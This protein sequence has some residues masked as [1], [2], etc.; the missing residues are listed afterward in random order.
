MTENWTASYICPRTFA[1]AVQ[2]PQPLALIHP[3]ILI[4]FELCAGNIPDK[5]FPLQPKGYIVSDSQKVAETWTPPTDGWMFFILHQFIS[6]EV[7]AMK[8]TASSHAANAVVP[9]RAFEIGFLS[10]FLHAEN[11]LKS[12]PW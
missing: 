1:P 10:R 8:S 6:D 12:L 5:P 4:D 9:E 11:S 3:R 7:R 2:V